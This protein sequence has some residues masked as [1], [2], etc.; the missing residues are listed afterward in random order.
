M[1]ELYTDGTFNSNV[2][3]SSQLN[4]WLIEAGDTYT[5]KQVFAPD[6]NR[7]CMLLSGNLSAADIANYDKSVKNGGSNIYIPTGVIDYPITVHTEYATYSNNKTQLTLNGQYPKGLNITFVNE[8]NEIC[9]NKHATVSITLDNTKSYS[10]T[11]NEIDVFSSFALPLACNKITITILYA[12]QDGSNDNVPYTIQG[13]LFG[14]PFKIPTENIKQYTHKVQRDITGQQRANESANIGVYRNDTLNISLYN[15]VVVQY[16]YNERYCDELR[17]LFISAI[18]LDTNSGD[19]EINAKD[20]LS[21]MNKEQSSAYYGDVLGYTRGKM[22]RYLLGCAV[23]GI[24]NLPSLSNAVDVNSD[25]SEDFWHPAQAA[26]GCLNDLYAQFCIFDGIAVPHNGIVKCET[27]IK[28]LSNINVRLYESTSQPQ[29][30]E[31]PALKQADLQLRTVKYGNT[32]TILTK[33]LPTIEA[34]RGYTFSVSFAEHTIVQSVK[35]A[36]GTEVKCEITNTG[37][38]SVVTIAEDYGIQYSAATIKVYG[39]KVE[40][41]T[42]TIPIEF[43]EDS[44][45]STTIENNAAEIGYVNIDV[46]ITSEDIPAYAKQFISRVFAPKRKYNVD[47]FGRFDLCNM[48]VIMIET[49]SGYL[50]KCSLTEYSL[51]YNGA[52][53]A[54]ITAYSLSN[55]KSQYITVQS[56]DL[57]AGENIKVMRG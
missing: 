39:C 18:E 17:Q 9:K 42:L 47:V 32:E 28:E 29:A 43:N 11:L 2:K 56:N 44:G 45:E 34:G 21:L 49:E 5:N 31:M 1:K 48:P 52:Y 10:F 27:P 30:T 15:S 35:L 55:G 36:N 57:Y 33:T 53:K 37:Y 14:A 26:S 7:R 50:E 54:S 23:S 3:E 8:V 38:V 13:I 12:K 46:G 6:I 16:I 4:V 22:R 20:I 41:G 25:E 40:I 51:E 24:N 19:I